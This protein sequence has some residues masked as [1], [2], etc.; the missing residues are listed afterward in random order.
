VDFGIAGILSNIPV[1]NIHAGTLKYL[2]PETFEKKSS[3]NIVSPALDVWSIGCILFALVTGGLP[4]K[5]TNTKNIIEKIKLCDYSYPSEVRL[6][7]EVRDLIGRCLDINPKSR[8][9][10]GE[11]SEHIWCK[12]DVG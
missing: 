1:D 5:G 9:T 2:A 6:S 8:I 3:L 11:I 10:M 4:F 7:H 12:G